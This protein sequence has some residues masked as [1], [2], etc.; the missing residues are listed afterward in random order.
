M[1]HAIGFITNIVV[2]SVLTLAIIAFSLS[3]ARERKHKDT[4]EAEEGLGR[5]IA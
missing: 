4:Q 1:E 5:K 3:E 2:L